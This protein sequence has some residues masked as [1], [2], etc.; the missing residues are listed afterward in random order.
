[1]IITKIHM[2]LRKDEFFDCYEFVSILQ[3][4]VIK[5]LDGRVAKIRPE[6]L[7]VYDYAPKMITQ[8]K[9][10]AWENHDSAKR[11]SF[12]LPIGVAVNLFRLMSLDS[13]MTKKAFTSILYHRLINVVDP[14]YLIWDFEGFM[15]FLKKNLE[16]HG[17]QV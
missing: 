14:E 15:P 10:R 2:K 9:L 16:S 7:A 5:E 3:M 12:E 17:Q 1:M 11:Y 4:V 13:N 6:V 8:N